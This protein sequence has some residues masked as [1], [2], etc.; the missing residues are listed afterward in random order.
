MPNHRS[1]L[2]YSPPPAT[3]L[4]N[5]PYLYLKN[6][7]DP[8]KIT[9]ITWK[10]VDNYSLKRY[11]FYGD[12]FPLGKINGSTLSQSFEVKS[13]DSLLGF[14]VI[15]ATYGQPPLTVN[16]DYKIVDSNY[17]SVVA[18]GQRVLEGVNDNQWGD[19]LF[20]KPVSVKKDGKYRI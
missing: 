18:K 9:G 7:V 16:V 20:Q 11:N 8:Q 2:P 4:C 17:G 19:I 3:G 12:Q 13:A 14:S 5:S 15:M 10:N 6:K 1:I